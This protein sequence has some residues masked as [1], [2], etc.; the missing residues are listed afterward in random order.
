[1][2]CCDNLSCRHSTSRHNEYIGQN[3]LRVLGGL[4]EAERTYLSRLD[5]EARVNAVFT[6]VLAMVNRRR[7]AGGVDVVPPALA[8][9]HHEMCI[10]MIGF[11]QACKL[12]DTPFPFPYAQVVSMVLAVFALTFPFIAVSQTAGIEG[13]RAWFLPLIIVFFT[14]MTY[15]GFHEV[16]RELEDPFVHPPNDLPLVSMHE[17]FN[18]RVT[19]SWEVIETDESITGDGERMRAAGL[20]GFSCTPASKLLD[21]WRQR[22]TLSG[23]PLP[24]PFAPAVSISEK[25]SAKLSA[26]RS[27]SNVDQFFEL[28][29]ARGSA[30]EPQPRTARTV[31]LGQDKKVSG[32]RVRN[33]LLGKQLTLQLRGVP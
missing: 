29:G 10:G 24:A 20:L 31:V 14:N 3:P 7:A 25:L 22:D 27:N 2:Y 18:A 33:G 16:A 4:S 6:Q 19:A 21:D 8:R 11:Q 9:F 5:S 30:G 13:E 17:I 26:K 32:S 12:E 1:M 15:F 28:Q 23:R